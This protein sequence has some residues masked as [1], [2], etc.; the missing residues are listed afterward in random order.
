MCQ[1]CARAQRSKTQ[2]MLI[3]QVKCDIGAFTN[4]GLCVVSDYRVSH[5]FIHSTTSQIFGKCSANRAAHKH[6]HIEIRHQWQQLSAF[7][8]P[9]GSLIAASRAA[10]YSY[11]S[12]IVNNC[13]VIIYKDTILNRDCCVSVL[14]RMMTNN[15]EKPWR[16]LM[17]YQ[18]GSECG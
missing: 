8:F 14:G 2:Q 16:K 10:S 7:S 1:R 13:D 5:Q 18:N 3:D 17:I 15:G 6:F 11:S 9:Y 12:T 4:G